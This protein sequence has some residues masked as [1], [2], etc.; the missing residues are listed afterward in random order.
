MMCSGVG[1]LLWSII[2]GTVCFIW[3]GG[4]VLGQLCS[5]WW[6][7]RGSWGTILCSFVGVQDCRGELVK[8]LSRS[9]AV[10]DSGDHIGYSR[11]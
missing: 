1:K 3:F 9:P 5:A 11:V 7:A 8:R 2:E 6:V 10:E 4:I